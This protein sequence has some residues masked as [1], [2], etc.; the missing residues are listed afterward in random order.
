MQEKTKELISQKLNLMINNIN[1]NN[2]IEDDNNFNSI[3][4]FSNGEEDEDDNGT[5]DESEDKVIVENSNSSP[6]SPSLIIPHKTPTPTK[7]PSTPTKPP[8]TPTKPPSTP[9]KTPSTP[10]DQDTP[11]SGRPKKKIIE[12]DEDSVPVFIKKT[13]GNLIP[14][15]DLL[16]VE[17]DEEIK[18]Q[19][20]WE[21]LAQIL[22]ENGTFI[23]ILKMTQ[24]ESLLSFNWIFNSFKLYLTQT[25]VIKPS[26][27]VMDY[28]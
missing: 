18:E 7:P 4:L 11:H 14:S 2:I 10:Q 6:A 23:L 1:N 16:V 19:Y 12:V 3:D 25:F 5:W 9:T 21:D 24:I 8:S 15:S 28:D 13:L 27:L 20:K 26:K 22:S 17:Y